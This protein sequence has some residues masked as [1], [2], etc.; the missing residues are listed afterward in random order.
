MKKRQLI[1]TIGLLTLLSC[2]FGQAGG[3]FF[4]EDFS[5]MDL[6]QV[7]SGWVSS[8]NYW[9][10]R[11]SN[12]AG[13]SSPELGFMSS[14]T[15]VFRIHTPAIDI[16][17]A[18]DLELIL[19][20]TTYDA[21]DPGPYTLKLDVS[22]DATNWT[23]VWS[24][25]DPSD[26]VYETFTYSL[27]NFASWDTI[28]LS[29][30]FDGIGYECDGWWI[31]DIFLYEPTPFP[32]EAVLVYP[33]DEAESILAP[34][35]LKWESGLSA[36]P[37]G[38]KL[39]FGE[40]NPP[41]LL[42]D[43]GDVT[44]YFT[45]DLQ[46]E[47]TYYWKIVPYNQ[48]GEDNTC[49]V[50]SFTTGIN[51][52]ITFPYAQNFDDV[53]RPTFPYGWRK[54]EEGLTGAA[55]VEIYHLT[56]PRSAPHHVRMNVTRNTGDQVLM[57]IS[58]PIQNISR[59]KII[60]WMKSGYLPNATPLEIGTMSD[61]FDPSTYEVYQTIPVSEMSTN[62]VEYTISFGDYEGTNNY[63]VFNKN[64]VTNLS[65]IA[66]IDDFVLEELPGDPQIVTSIQSMQLYGT[67]NESS[68]VYK[69]QITN[70]GTGTLLL[71]E[72][73]VEIIGENAADFDFVRT[74][75]PLAIP[76]QESATMG[77]I[78][79]PSS[80]GEKLATLSL[81]GNA[82]NTPY[83]I[84]LNGTAFPSGTAVLGHGTK[85]TDSENE[86]VL[87]IFFKWQKSQSVYTAAELNAA[88]ISGH[89]LLTQFGYYV[90]S[91][92]NS[93]LT[94]FQ[95]RMKHTSMQSASAH[96]V[97][98]NE[99]D[100]VYSNAAYMPVAGGYDLLTLDRPFGWNGV[101]NILVEVYFGPVDT[102]SG[103]GRT[104]IY[105]DPVANGFRNVRSSV[106]DIAP[107]HT[108][109]VRNIKF[110]ALMKFQDSDIGAWPVLTKKS[111][112]STVVP[113]NGTS[114]ESLHLFNAGDQNLSYSVSV[115]DH[116]GLFS[117]VPASG[118]L[119][120]GAS[121]L[122]TLQ[123]NSSGFEAG[124]YTFNLLIS[125]NA[126]FE[127]IVV[128]CKVRVLPNNTFVWEDFSNWP[129][130]EWST[131]SSGNTTN[132]AIY[133]SVNAQCEM[134]EMQLYI[135]PSHGFQGT[136]RLISPAMDTRG[137]DN[138]YVEFNHALGSMISNSTI[139]LETSSNLTD[140]NYIEGFP[141]NSFTGTTYSGVISSSDVGSETFYVAWTY[142][143]ATMSIGISWSIDDVIITG[144][145]NNGIIAGQ[146]SLSLPD[147]LSNVQ[148]IVNER[149]YYPDMEGLFSI[150]L[151]PGS[152]HVVVKCDGYESQVARN[153]VVT[154][155]NT[156]TLEFN[157]QHPTD[158]LYPAT[159]FNADVARYNTVQLGWQV[160]NIQE[161]EI[162]FHD[163][164]ANQG[165]SVGEHVD[166]IF[167]MRLTETELQNYYGWNIKDVSFMLHEMEFENAVVQI[168]EGGGT[169][170]AGTLIYE[171]NVNNKAI[172]KIWVN[173][174]INETIT[175]LPDTEYW[176]AYY[177]E[178]AQGYPAA[179][180]EG[181]AVAG[182][183]DMIYKNGQ[184]Q[185]LS[186]S[187]GISVNWIIN[188]SLTSP[189]ER[190]ADALTNIN[191]TAIV[192]QYY[193]KNHAKKNGVGISDRIAA[194]KH[195]PSRSIQGF[196]LFRDGNE[197][198]TFNILS[199]NDTDLPAGS[200][201]YSLRTNYADGSIFTPYELEVMI[202]LP[203]PTDL[204]TE[205]LEKNVQ[206]SWQAPTA[207][208]TGVVSY[209][210][211][212]NDE[213]VL[214]V[215]GTSCVL[216]NLEVGE[217]VLNV[218]A[219]YNGNHE[220]D[221]SENHEFIVE[222]TSNED[223]V[224]PVNALFSNY[225]NPFNPHTNIQY[226]V[227]EPTFVSLEIFN[228]KGQKVRTLVN[229]FVD[230]SLHTVRWDGK[231]DNNNKV[232]SGVYFYRIKTSSFTQM[233]KMLLMK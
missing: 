119:I 95:I 102:T 3:V 65:T 189:Q 79:S 37:T 177:L 161:T 11:N 40:E 219:I 220:G 93:I 101:D 172:D 12:D 167:A 56:A 39:Y 99:A 225:P 47:T 51:P 100:V 131:Y 77:I 72:S 206:A 200:Y 181:P 160:P 170:G 75:F 61:P 162:F 34:L 44:S 58:P 38:Y 217:Y 136:Q 203:A 88:G 73:D 188:V 98:I 176:I 209:K 27:S 21:D 2:L 29:W 64:T 135:S 154:A 1:L 113:Y 48:I 232:S 33:P 124:I 84:D 112:I 144:A 213:F 60:F 91:A 138:M 16:S 165:I 204:Q 94:N 103:S 5:G 108:S 184:W 30:V 178:A 18:S 6:N 140:W 187:D 186:Q 26:F 194:E 216:E 152:Y 157:L 195:N 45:G 110:Q 85:G 156:E 17:G 80:A 222:P 89:Q 53:V 96:E 13:G 114:Q 132:W 4:Q 117:S 211:Y 212:L 14:E 183:G 126:M 59:S 133:Q 198:Q 148:I 121:E 115:D 71:E 196:T 90:D 57:L 153:V 127:D 197:I 228:S 83:L 227:K 202:D 193:P 134:P 168:Y 82:V 174:R 35:F 199:Y 43:L 55:G 105:D 8:S 230:G 20:Q 122:I 32:G 123:F 208:A 191:N 107:D 86:G 46:L 231:D 116:Q 163:G 111:R 214:N 67:E 49:P 15:G 23:T 74:N 169:T 155:G 76:E 81:S 68:P 207:F 159:N 52:T 130:P 147:V 139:R 201:S 106:N 149:I 62:Y 182:K 143:S 145:Q 158:V 223:L 87:N 151:Y 164:Y 142:E 9:K 24:V 19:T 50:W 129:S 25:V 215:N 141:S 218:A 36:E 118:A 109:Q 146:V 66:Y 233:K 42:Q 97:D 150:S 226:S 78:F 7:P 210:V 137:F 125:H 128:P 10:V 205:V 63:I 185:S 190:M 104:R 92:P 179:C 166:A 28:Y 175:I 54:I 224:N 69:L 41:P 180:D 221:W 229:E 120:S 173:Q 171:Q 70:G 22:N 192:S 31:D